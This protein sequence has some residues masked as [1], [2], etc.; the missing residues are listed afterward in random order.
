MADPMV[1][2]QLPNDQDTTMGGAADPV[3]TDNA[4][5]TAENTDAAAATGGD[6]DA[7]ADVPVEEEVVLNAGQKFVK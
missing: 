6:A 7:E 5:N 1:S 3:A 2:V 4:E